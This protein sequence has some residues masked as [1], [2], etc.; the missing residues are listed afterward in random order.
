MRAAPTGSG[1]TAAIDIPQF[2]RMAL[3]PAGT[4]RSAAIALVAFGRTALLD[5]LNAWCPSCLAYDF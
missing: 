1:G 5:G 4:R 3:T 2:A